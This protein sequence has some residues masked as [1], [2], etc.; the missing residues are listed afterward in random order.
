MIKNRENLSIE[1]KNLNKKKIVNVRFFFFLHPSL[2]G[3]SLA[4]SSLSSMNEM[5]FDVA[6]I[7]RNCSSSFLR[8]ETLFRFGEKL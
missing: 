8:I 7:L 2:V 3:D 6:T 4:P 5:L 1:T